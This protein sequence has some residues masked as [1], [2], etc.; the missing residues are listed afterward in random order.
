MPTTENNQN[1]NEIGNRDSF[2]VDRDK[3]MFSTEFRRLDGK[4]QVFVSGFDDHMRNRLTHTLEVSQIATSICKDIQLNTTLAEAISLGHDIGH[5]P[6]GH[7]GERFLNLL[8][9]NCIKKIANKYKVASTELGFK[10]NLQGVKVATKLE[11]V[12]MSYDGLGLTEYTLWGIAHHS[13]LKYNNCKDQLE[14]N[15][16]GLF[17]Q[18]CKNKLNLTHYS[19]ILN[20]AY[21]E[22]KHWSSE[23]IIVKEADEIA[24]RHHDIEDGI[25]AKLIDTETLIS[26]IRK[27]LPDNITERAKYLLYITENSQENINIFLHNIA[28]FIIEVY[29]SELIKE[30]KSFEETNKNTQIKDIDYTTFFKKP[31]SSSFIDFN[32]YLSEQLQSYILCSQMANQMDGKANYILKKLAEAYISNPRTLPDKTLSTLYYRI[33][34]Q[35]QDGKQ[36]RSN[37]NS[38]KNNAS[39]G[40][41]LIRIVTDYIAG[42]TDNYAIAQ[43][44]LLYGSDNYWSYL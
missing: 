3:I 7:V 12:S 22:N 21:D 37:I 34:G 24:Q 1:K 36:V 18:E 25:R 13:K 20:E 6:F 41:H 42:M 43:Y 14:A 5:T 40:N 9:N 8:T 39:F 15:T 10:H 30:F 31:Y 4:T 23:A 27:E 29:S 11:K 32:D 35:Q 38:L 28:S 44:K 26:I 16:C 33:N 19:N 2:T 17:N